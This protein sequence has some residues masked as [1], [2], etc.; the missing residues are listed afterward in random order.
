MTATT[1][2]PLDFT[3]EGPLVRQLRQSY[4]AEAYAAF[5]ALMM[6]AAAR[7]EDLA[8]PSQSH[9]M[10]LL[11]FGER[12]CL[13]P[14][15]IQD[16]LTRLRGR[17]MQDETLKSVWQA[18]ARRQVFRTRLHALRRGPL[19]LVSLGLHCLPWTLVNRWGFRTADQFVSLFNPFSMAV[20][21]AATVAEAIATDFASYAD[22][23][24]MREARTPQGQRIAMRRDGGAVWNHNRGDSWLADDHARLRASLA[25]KAEAFRQSCRAPGLVFLM[26]DCRIDDPA[27]PIP[28]LDPLRAALRG[29]TGLPNP[30]LILTSQRRRG[31]RDDL[32]WLD[33]DTA[34]ISAPY[35]HPRYVWADDD[36]AD[37]ADGLAFEHG[38]AVALLRCL[39]RWD[40]ADRPARTAA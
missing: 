6:E 21:K 15:L 24:D 32:T 25:A 8:A 37:S 2:P 30:R 31:G 26:G 20:H 36:Q 14:P 3:Q 10:F 11:R 18:V 29:V 23:A 40:M 12:A 1:T 22:P 16:L 34:L 17:A 13:P 35:P 39:V 19:A 4:H 7:V 27:A 28:F 9:L 38:Y 5:Q 33:A